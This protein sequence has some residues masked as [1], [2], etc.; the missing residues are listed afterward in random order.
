MEVHLLYA[1]PK[2]LAIS[3]IRTCWK[4][5][6]KEDGFGDNDSQL[7]RRI[8]GFG[9]TSTLEH[10]QYT[11]YV[12]GLSRAILQELARHRIASFSVES[13]RYTL[14]R[15][16]NG[17]ENIENLMV[18][19]GDPDLDALTHKHM[20]ELKKLINR[21]GLRN[22]TAKYGIT[23]NYPVNLQFSMNI[24]SLRNFVTLRSGKAAHKE[25]QLLARKVMEVIP[26]DHMIFF[27]DLKLG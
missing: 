17:E 23:E 8:I 14:K 2:E 26:E 13:T 11:F 24:R 20:R 7:I 19:T 10:I 22:D 6:H 9:H 25:I 21:K 15:I 1:P 5:F 18:E 12:K 16:L 3:A 27:E 4:S